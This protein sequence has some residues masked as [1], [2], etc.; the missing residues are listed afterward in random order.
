MPLLRARRI[1]E[2]A[3]AHCSATNEFTKRNESEPTARTSQT[4]EPSIKVQTVPSKPG[5]G[6]GAAADKATS[7]STANLCSAGQ[8]EGNDWCGDS[9]ISTAVV[10]NTFATSNSAPQLSNV[11]P[12]IAYTSSDKVA[13]V[14]ASDDTGGY[15]LAAAATPK[16]SGFRQ[17]P[18]TVSDTGDYGHSPNAQRVYPVNP[19][20]AQTSV[21]HVHDHIAIAAPTFGARIRIDILSSSAPV[22]GTSATVDSIPSAIPDP[23]QWSHQTID[24]PP[25]ITLG[26]SKPRETDN[27]NFVS[28]TTSDLS[29]SVAG[30][31]PSVIPPAFVGAVPPPLE[32]GAGLDVA[33]KVPRAS[34]AFSSGVGVSAALASSVGAGLSA[35]STDPWQLTDTGSAGSSALNNSPAVG[36]P[37]ADISVKTQPNFIATARVQESGSAHKVQASSEQRFRLVTPTV[38][39]DDVEHAMTDQTVHSGMSSNPSERT[40]EAEHVISADEERNGRKVASQSTNLTDIETIRLKTVNGETDTIVGSNLSRDV[41]VAPAIAEGVDSGTPQVVESQAD[42]P[43]STEHVVSD[44][45]VKSVPPDQPAKQIS[46]QLATA[47]ASNVNVVFTEKSGKVDIAVRTS[48]PQLASSLKSDVGEL[49]A[50]LG[51]SGFKTEIYVPADVRNRAAANLTFENPQKSQSETDNFNGGNGRRQQQQQQNGD[52]QRH[53]ARWNAQVR[54]V[55]SGLAAGRYVE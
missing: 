51:E 8:A 15:Q 40:S 29:P 21:A 49:V 33:T 2:I 47:T 23:K 11:M 3:P 13:P 20:A 27:A 39:S 52:G 18:L 19:D 55:L 28:S 9:R 31:A 12:N 4:A 16:T 41:F 30:P 34:S 7:L 32:G 5:G 43:K 14:K 22:E 38:R 45:Q 26:T 42:A 17:E 54:E 50:R 53:R 35:L 36:A 10:P 24:P 37:A 1:R 46:F 6:P 48:D 25:G 44:V